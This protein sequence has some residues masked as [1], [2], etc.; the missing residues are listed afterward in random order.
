MDYRSITTLLLRLTGVVIL[1]A[2]LIQAP[3]WIVSLILST[4]S[5][6]VNAGDWLLTAVPSTVSTLIGLLL[7]YF[8]ATVAN[9][10]V[11]GGG[12]SMDNRHLE[13]I[14][15]SILGLYFVATAMFDGVYL[16]AKLRLYPL[17]FYP[18]LSDRPIR[19]TDSQ[20]ADIASTGTQF[21]VGVAL[22]FGGRGL[23]NIV[24]RLRT[25]PALP[26]MCSSTPDGPASQARG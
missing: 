5:G 14:G 2:A 18:D 22:L 17:I 4:A 10:I 13:Q 25:P 8:P 16:L 23:A 12:E 7:I 15:F 20:F 9:R 1:A 24:H 6:G 19:L 3:K 11:S 26:D 21:V